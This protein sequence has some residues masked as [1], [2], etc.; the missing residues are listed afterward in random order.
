ME[1][2]KYKPKRLPDAYD[3]EQINDF[4]KRNLDVMGYD[5]DMD[6][7]MLRSIIDAD[8]VVVGGDRNGFYIKK[9]GMIIAHLSR[10]AILRDKDDPEDCD[11]TETVDPARRIFVP[12]NGLKR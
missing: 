10:K 8:G 9:K 7:D 12:V 6:P 4:I 11:D 2:F 5:T 3:L 1:T